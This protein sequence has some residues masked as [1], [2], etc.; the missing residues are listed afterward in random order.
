MCIKLSKFHN[1]YLVV[2]ISN[3]ILPH[4]VFSECSHFLF[5][6]RA[7]NRIIFLIYWTYRDNFYHV[8]DWNASLYPHAFTYRKP[9]SRI[10]Y[11]VA[12]I[13]LVWIDTAPM[14]KACCVRSVGWVRP[15]MYA[16]VVLKSLS[17]KTIHKFK[18]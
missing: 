3:K 17:L 9:I 14:W 7:I 13:K 4:E 15:L 11:K 18:I 5:P 12:N 2:Q 16:K 1:L 6:K 10:H 8:L